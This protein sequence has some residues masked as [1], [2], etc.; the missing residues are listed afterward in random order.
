MTG[1]V[2]VELRDVTKTFGSADE[3]VTAL[4]DA[5]LRISA[6]EVV[7]LRGRS[8]S[9][10]TTL[11]NL[12]AGWLQPDGGNIGW[13]AGLGG[14]PRWWELSI[15][16]QALGLLDELNI[17][18]NVVLPLRFGDPPDP[19]AVTVLL[20]DLDIGHLAGRAVGEAS[21]G[22]QQRTAVAR[23]LVVQPRLVLA[24]EPTAH[25]DLDHLRLVWGLLARA[26]ATGSAVLAATHNPEALEYATRVVDLVAGSLV[27]R[28]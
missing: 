1:G 23:A 18:E 28:D 17:A 21:L 10:K 26:A 7:L 24:D 16:P 6:G 12:L 2:L 3:R 8:G 11:I 15:I 9:G 14:S 13:A 22:E 27:E 25:Q 5:S 19:T 20:E 4:R